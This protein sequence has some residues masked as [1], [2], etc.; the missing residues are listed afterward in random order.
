MLGSKILIFLSSAFPQYFNSDLCAGWRWSWYTWGNPWATKLFKICKVILHFYKFWFIVVPKLFCFNC[1][2]LPWGA[3]SFLFG[4]LFSAF[5]CIFI[6]ICCMQKTRTFWNSLF[7]V[8]V[9]VSWLIYVVVDLISETIV[10]FQ[11]VI[12]FL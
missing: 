8:W 6:L 1:P 12:A 2:E 10:V 7:I 11:A 3:Y 5:Y 9:Q 4:S